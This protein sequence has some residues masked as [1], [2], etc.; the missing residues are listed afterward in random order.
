MM[1]M[2]DFVEPPDVLQDLEACGPESIFEVVAVIAH[3]IGLPEAPQPL[4]YRGLR[5][6]FGRDAFEA[7]YAA[8]RA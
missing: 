3:V 5:V 2:L 8:T 4:I 1:A 7:R 6:F